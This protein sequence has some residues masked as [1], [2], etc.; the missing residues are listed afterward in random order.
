MLAT[1]SFTVNTETKETVRAGNIPSR[2]ALA[3]LQD[4]VQQEAINKA[5]EAKAE[6]EKGEPPSEK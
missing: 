4:I 2:Q 5:L 1:Y 6:E 3:I